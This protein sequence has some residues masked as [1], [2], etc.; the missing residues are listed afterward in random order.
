MQIKY[1][2]FSNVKEWTINEGSVIRV[3]DSLNRVI[4]EKEQPVLKDYFYV[5]NIGRLDG[6]L[7]IT[8]TTE[9]APV[10]EVFKSTDRINWTSMGTTSATAITADIPVK[11]KLY[12]KATADAWGYIYG[13]NSIVFTDN[14][15]IGG[16]I[17]SLL[18]GDNFEN[19]TTFPSGTTHNFSDLFNIP[20]LVSAENL[21]LPATK[22]TLNCYS[23]MFQGCTSL[24]TAP[25]LPATTLAQ[26]CYA[27]M[28]YGCVSLNSVTIYATNISANNCLDGWL[29]KV[30][31][32][33]TF[34]NMACTTYPSGSSGIP[35]GWTELH[36]LNDTINVTIHN[37]DLSVS[38]ATYQIDDGTEQPISETGDTVFTI[39]T[40]ATT[41]TINGSRMVIEATGICGYTSGKSM[42]VNKMDDNVDISLTSMM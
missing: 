29:A 35:S 24:T 2:N 41:L 23:R 14:C 6:K 8:K 40:T 33:G 20:K 5:E 25:A 26:N 18:Y 17:M 1:M 13:T 27:S 21:I 22:L 30:S 28:F 9:N 34:H 16:N 3:T 36:T 10:I 32:T 37:V 12:L 31:S 39:P 4:W 42:P 19:Q 38:G 7:S 15:N 11:K